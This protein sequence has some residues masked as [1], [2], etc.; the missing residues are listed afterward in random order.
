MSKRGHVVLFFLIETR[1]I[2][3]LYVIS[4]KDNGASQVRVV[5]EGLHITNKKM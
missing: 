5:I 4:I 3:N 1:S 2:A